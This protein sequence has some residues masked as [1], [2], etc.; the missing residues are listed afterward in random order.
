M[1]FMYA[2]NKFKQWEP[3]GRGGGRMSYVAHY[4]FI[5]K[6]YIQAFKKTFKKTQFSAIQT[7]K[8]CMKCKLIISKNYSAGK[9]TSVR[10][11]D[12][13]LFPICKLSKTTFNTF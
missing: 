5:K 7:K 12:A 6:K 1:A 4:S 3:G 11:V 13:T 10:S 2:P 8:I 9:L